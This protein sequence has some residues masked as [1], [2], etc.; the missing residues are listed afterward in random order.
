M[1]QDEWTSQATAAPE[2]SVPGS[3][4][5]LAEDMLTDTSPELRRLAALARYQLEPDAPLDQRS[6]ERLIALAAR[7]FS[8]ETALISFIGDGWQWWGAACGMES[9]DLPETGMDASQSMC[10]AVVAS[11]QPLTIPDM[12]SDDTYRQHPLA[13]E[14]GVRFYASEPL[15]TPD[16]YAIGTLCL[17]DVRPRDPLTL[18]EQQ[19]LADLAQLIMDEL[20]LRLLALEQERQ[21]SASDLL[22]ESLREALAYAET[23][24]AISALSELGLSVDELLFQAVALCASVCDTDLGS[25]VALHEDRAFIFPAWHSPR[26]AGLSDAVSRGLKRSECGQLWTSAFSDT[27]QPLFLNTYPSHPW[28]HL[29]MV[30]A[31]VMAQAY[32]PMGGRGETRFLMVLSRVHRDRPWRP[33]QRQLVTAVARMMRD[34]S[35]QR[36]QQEELGINIAQLDLALGSAPLVLFSVDRAGIFRL[37]RGSSEETE[38]WQSL[39]GRSVDEAFQA[40]PQVLHNI[41]RAMSG[42]N[43]EDVVRIAEQV[44]DVRYIHAQDAAGRPAGALGL[45]YNVTSLAQAEQRATAAK[46]ESEALLGLAQVVTGDVLDKKVADAAL[47]SL[48]RAT[49]GGL[50]TLWQLR[51]ERYFPVS[52]RGTAPGLD[53][54][55][56]DRLHGGGVPVSVYDALVGVVDRNVYLRASSLPDALTRAGVGGL[57]ALP[58]T[59]KNGRCQVGLVAYLHRPWKPAERELLETACAIFGAGLERRQQLTELE[60]DAATDA[61][62]GVGNR[63]A[64]NL[65]LV[66]AL[67]RA[68]QDRAAQHRAAQH[69]SAPQAE[70]GLW[71]VSIDLDGL[72]TVNDLY[73][74]ARGDALLSQF[75]ADLRG[76]LPPG[77]ELFRLGGDEFVVVYPFGGSV[78]QITPILGPE[79]PGQQSAGQP[80]AGQQPKPAELDWLHVAV[81]ATRL[82]GFAA[83]SASAGAARFPDDASSAAELLCLSD[84][85]LYAEKEQRGSGRVA[86][87]EN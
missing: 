18:S 31:G 63:R 70:A 10:S 75:A 77:G 82:A 46:R 40:V 84:E 50:L 30:R 67:N 55:R 23:L 36:R 81:R 11:G 43:F 76:S 69:V 20:E 8:V 27:Q 79:L 9:L 45:G 6:F 13:A 59:V 15:L 78:E 33:Y 3:R 22:S 14:N 38:A 58:L 52:Q 34:L 44:Y 87:A 54:S 29:A 1:D 68:A 85:R 25:L 39:V 56:L 37:V 73:G 60:R 32:A 28:A 42:E 2:S 21:A 65:A 16:G 71:V 74:H 35:Q 66:A 86:G 64:L 72:K 5:T 47:D 51:G 17:M 57:A 41:H 61:L 4:F 12:S 49:D 83:A 53:L 19:T 7:L 48:S 62:T 24:Q 80:P 26:A